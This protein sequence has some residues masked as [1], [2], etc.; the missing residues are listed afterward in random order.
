M[1]SIPA[2]RRARATTFAPRSCPSNPGFA[3]NTR[4]LRS[5]NGSTAFQRGGR[6]EKRRGRRERRELP[7]SMFPP[8][9]PP[10]PLRSFSAFS[11]LKD[12]RLDVL[13]PD[14][15]QRVAHLAES[16]VGAGGLEDRL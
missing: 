2:S 3:I 1:T 6:G 7:R 16:G 8:F 11:A 14:L 10:R 4:S 13:A 15:A 9:V 12:R 5:G